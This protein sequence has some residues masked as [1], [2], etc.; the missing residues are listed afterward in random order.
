[1]RLLFASTRADL[2][3]WSHT[4]LATRDIL[5]L[6]AAQGWDCRAIHCGVLEA[7]GGTSLDEVLR[8]LGIR[9]RPAMAR[10]GGGNGVKVLDV[11][12]R[13]IKGILLPT[14]SSLDEGSPSPREA[15]QFITLVQQALERF[16]PDVLLVRGPHDADGEVVFR[17]RRLGIPVVFHLRDASDWNQRALAQANAVLV[18][19]EYA[20]RQ[21][22]EHS[23][24]ESTAIPHPL[25]ANALVGGFYVPQ[26]ATFVDPTPAA[27]VTVFARIA[28]EMGRRRPDIPF[29]VVR[30][31]SAPDWLSAVPLDL[32][33][34]TNLG[35]MEMTRDSRDYL[36]VTRVLL[37]PSLAHQ[38]FIRAASEGLANAVPS[39]ASDRGALPEMLGGAGFVFTLSERL[40]PAVDRVP[41]PREVAPWLI[42][43]EKLWDDPA[44]E[45]R[46]RELAR[47]EGERWAAERLS[48]EYQAFFQRVAGL[49]RPSASEFEG[50]Q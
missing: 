28:L 6:L 7:G 46:H 4:T 37:L 1:M 24:T 33:G 8:S 29:L 13:G 9:S 18:P 48:R 19:S 34:L 43:L 31:N 17:A 14:A 32:S 10:V 3:C 11:T 50:S 25:R 47:A 36:K 20:R 38:T 30:D 40:T 41:L 23:G 2:G 12:F 42:T 45:A 15:G 5:E 39:L 21:L 16:Q 35:Q 27:G 49:A 44:C 26:Y 22:K